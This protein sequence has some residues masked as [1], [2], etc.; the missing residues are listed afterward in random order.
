MNRCPEWCIDCIQNCLISDDSVFVFAKLSRPRLVSL[1]LSL[2]LQD[3][4]N[5]TGKSHDVIF[6][7]LIYKSINKFLRSII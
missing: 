7:K 1:S 6:A 5:K 4:H 2:D 3:I